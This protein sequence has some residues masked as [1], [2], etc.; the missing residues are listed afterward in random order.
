MDR[1]LGRTHHC[2]CCLL[3]VIVLMTSARQLL[4]AWL[5]G[6]RVHLGALA[7]AKEKTGRRGH[8]LDSSLDINDQTHSPAPRRP[9]ESRE[10]LYS[11][12]FKDCTQGHFLSS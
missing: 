12:I 8:G 1:R 4:Q 11:L 3:F 2:P 5:S 9:K 7:C 6:Y 10:Q